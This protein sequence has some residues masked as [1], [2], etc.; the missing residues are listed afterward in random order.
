[1]SSLL[2]QLIRSRWTHYAALAVVVLSFVL[3]PERGFGVP[4]CQ[5]RT[6]THLPCMACGLTRSYIAL[7]HLNLSRAA[8]YHPFGLLLFPLTVGL[9]ALLVVPA[10]ARRRLTKWAETR[11]RPLHYMGIGLF[12]V[13]MVYGLGR[14][15]WLLITHR[16]SP[17]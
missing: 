5:F 1:M 9:A 15:G 4:L 13:F 6:V 10:T 12:V 17:W 8:F 16:P 7:A 2:V 14:M 11:Q 3:P